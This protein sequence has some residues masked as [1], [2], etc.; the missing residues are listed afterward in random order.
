[1]GYPVVSLWGPVKSETSLDQL[2]ESL[3]LGYVQIE[4]LNVASCL[5][6]AITLLDNCTYELGP[7]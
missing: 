6:F 4:R 3:P 7:Y 5:L 2:S 1:M